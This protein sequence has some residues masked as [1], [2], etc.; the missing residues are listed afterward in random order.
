MHTLGTHP[1]M[2]K[3]LENLQPWF[4]EE[5]EEKKASLS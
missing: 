1:V 5:E 2:K 3:K 4:L